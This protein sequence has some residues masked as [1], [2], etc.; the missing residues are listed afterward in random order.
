MDLCHID[1]LGH[2]PVCI[3]CFINRVAATSQTMHS[4]VPGVI[5]HASSLQSNTKVTTGH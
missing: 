3:T 5:F 4:L 1:I 2:C